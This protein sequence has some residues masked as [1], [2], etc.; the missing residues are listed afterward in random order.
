MSVPRAEEIFV[1]LRRGVPALV[2]GKFVVAAQVHRHR[3][4]AVRAARKELR[5]YR[6]RWRPICRRRQHTVC[7]GEALRF[8]HRADGFLVVKRLLTARLTALKQA[9]V[10]LRVEKTLFVKARLLEAVVDVRRDDKIVLVPHQLEQNLVHA[11]RRVLIAVDEDIPAPIGPEL[12]LRRKRIEPTAVHVVEAV[13]FR[14]IRKIPL[15][16]LT[17][18]REARRG[19]QPCARADDDSIRPV[20]RAPQARNLRREAARRSFCRDP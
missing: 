6:H 2:L 7:Y 11:F 3:S 9:V 10:A 12:L 4:A 15:E 5:R 14:K 19:G 13:F 20:K 1:P 18:V 8:D 17:I 16:P